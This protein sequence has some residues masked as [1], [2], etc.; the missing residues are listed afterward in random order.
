MDVLH[1]SPGAGPQDQNE[2]VRQTMRRVFLM[3]LAFTL[4]GCATKNFG[5][6][7]PLTDY[8]RQNLSCSDIQMEQAKVMGFAQHVDKQSQ[9]DG[10]DVLAAFGDFGI[11]NSAARSAAIESAQQRYYQLEVAAYDKGCTTVKPE[12]PP[13]PS[14]YESRS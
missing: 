2:A 13:E 3:A 8:E 9:F 4:A 11:G 7:P 6:Q 12:P 14:R 1:R 5:T 10:R